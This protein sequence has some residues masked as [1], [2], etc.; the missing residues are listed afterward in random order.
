MSSS[1][2]MP[3]SDTSIS[4]LSYQLTRSP[5]TEA[6]A[7]KPSTSLIPPEKPIHFPSPSS[8]LPKP[9]LVISSLK[10]WKSRL[11]WSRRSIHPPSKRTLPL[12]SIASSLTWNAGQSRPPKSGVNWPLSFTMKVP[13]VTSKPRLSRSSRR[14]SAL[15]NV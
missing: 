9:S 2:P 12:E 15:V 1:T 10:P 8:V 6:P 14:T 3:L 11:Y 4:P 13:P 7:L 5:S